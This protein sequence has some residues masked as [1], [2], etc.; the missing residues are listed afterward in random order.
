[1]ICGCAEDILVEYAGILD[2]E[3]PTYGVYD[4]LVLRDDERRVR[5][6]R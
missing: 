4:S 6:N 3:N 1:M 2:S 5:Q